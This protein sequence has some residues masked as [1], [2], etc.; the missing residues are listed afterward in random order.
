[1]LTEFVVKAFTVCQMRS[2]KTYN[3]TVGFT[4]GADSDF[5]LECYCATQDTYNYTVW[6]TTR[7]DSDF[8]LKCYIG[9]GEEP[10]GIDC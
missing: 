10:E 9:R 8:A 2:Q 1:M 5:A 3:S 4:T 7:A 6:F